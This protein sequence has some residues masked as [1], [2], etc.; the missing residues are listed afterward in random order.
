MAF[1]LEADTRIPLLKLQESYNIQ[2]HDVVHF[3]LNKGST[4]TSPTKEEIGETFVCEDVTTGAGA[5]LVGKIIDGILCA[6]GAGYTDDEVSKVGHLVEKN[7]YTCHSAQVEEDIARIV[8]EEGDA[9]MDNKEAVEKKVDFMLKGLLDTDVVERDANVHVNSNEPV[10]LIN[11]DQNEPG[12]MDSAQRDLMNYVVDA[13]VVALQQKWNIW[14]VRVYAGA[15]LPGWNNVQTADNIAFS[16]T[17]L[18]VVNT[19]I[20]GPSMPQLLDA[21]CSATEWDR[22]ARMEVWR[23]RDLVSRDDRDAM[24]KDDNLNA[25]EHSFGSNDDDN[26]SV[27]SD[28]LSPAIL[29]AATLPDDS[30]EPEPDDT[31]WHEE[32]QVLP[33]APEDGEQPP[34]RPEDIQ[35]HEAADQGDC[36]TRESLKQEPFSSSQEFE[37]PERHIEHPTWARKDD[38]MSLLD[39]IRSQASIIAPFGTQSTGHGVADIDAVVAGEDP[40]RATSPNSSKDVGAASGPAKDESRGDDEFVV[41]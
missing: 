33:D 11:I 19:D 37:L 39:L 38:S 9:S 14:P 23:G 21:S 7:L 5:L 20:G 10:L 30:N 24:D 1:R 35:T 4:D 18:N 3:A 27:G 34:P 6:E 31:I 2:V 13:S 32:P 28:A 16:L 22:I 29:Q 17:L 26:K 25:S 8:P 36:D 12:H 15:V 41:L 40:S